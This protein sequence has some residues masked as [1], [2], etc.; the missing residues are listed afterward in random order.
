MT[1]VQYSSIQQSLEYGERRSEHRR[2]VLKGGSLLFN[3]GYAS[4]D[5]RVKNLSTQGAL[6][7]MSETTGLPSE[8]DF[9]IGEEKVTKPAKII[10][11]DQ[12]RLG[13]HFQ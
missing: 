2:R 13:I 9:R 6:L 12:M 4:Y 5:C 1:Q 8:F 7:E 3:N 10:W 11:R